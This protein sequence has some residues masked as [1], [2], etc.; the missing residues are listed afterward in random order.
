LPPWAGGPSLTPGPITAACSSVGDEGIY[1][2]ANRQQFFK[3]FLAPIKK[4]FKKEKEKRMMK[5]F[6]VERN[7]RRYY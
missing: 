2:P 6:T 7:T 4:I 5:Q 3:K 1:H